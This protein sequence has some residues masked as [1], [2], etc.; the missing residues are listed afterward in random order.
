[1]IVQSLLDTDHYKITMDQVIF[2]HFPAAVV[3]YRFINRGRAA[4]RGNIASSSSRPNPAT[5]W[6]R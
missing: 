3:R 4:S 2:F 5:A 1:M 6:C